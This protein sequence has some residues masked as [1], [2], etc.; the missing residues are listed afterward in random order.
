MLKVKELILIGVEAMHCLT[1]GNATTQA[2][3]IGAAHFDPI[4]KVL[5]QTRYQSVQ[6][7]NQFRPITCGVRYY[8]RLPAMLAAGHS[9]LP[10]SFRSSFFLSFFLSSFFR[11]LISEVAWPIVTKLCHM[12]NGDPD[13]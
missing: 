7:Y 12:F 2:A 10:L 5:T 8:G 13:L 6:V 4:I 1:E 11:R 9:L 3:V